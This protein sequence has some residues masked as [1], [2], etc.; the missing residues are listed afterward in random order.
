MP[1]NRQERVNGARHGFR[2]PAGR[3]CRRKTLP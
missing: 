1:A 2:D 3:N